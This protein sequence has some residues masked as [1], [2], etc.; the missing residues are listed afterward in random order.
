NGDLPDMGKARKHHGKLALKKQANKKRKYINQGTRLQSLRTKI[1]SA[2][3]ASYGDKNTSELRPGM[4][5][6]P[7]MVRKVKCAML[8]LTCGQVSGLKIAHLNWTLYS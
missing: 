5:Y 1:A 6:L 3:T 8:W 2:P 7:K 4:A